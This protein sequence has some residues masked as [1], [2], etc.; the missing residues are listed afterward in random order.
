MSMKLPLVL[1]TATLI[2]GGFA[3]SL[4]DKV[5]LPSLPANVAAAVR[6]EP[7][8]VAQQAVPAD[9][10]ALAQRILTVQ[11]EGQ[12]A[13]DTAV[14]PAAMQ[15]QAQLQPKTRETDQAGDP[16]PPA[17]EP[18]PE[19]DLSALRYFAA[20]GDNARLQAEIA[21]LRALY[22]DWTPPANPLE[23]PM[24]QDERLEEVWR[25]YAEGRYSEVRKAIAERQAMDRTWQPPQDLLERLNLAENRVR[26]INASDLKQYQTVITLAAEAPAL[27]TCS[28]VD[29]LWRLAEAFTRTD[30]ETR[31]VDVY[32][33]VLENCTVEQQRVA[34]VQKAAALLSSSS[35]T[36][37]LA[38]E[39]EKEFEPIRNDLARRLVA[40]ANETPGSD[41]APDYL[42]RLR[43][44]AEAEGKASDALL[45]G[46]YALRHDEARQ[47]EQ[48]FSK[49]GQI[50]KSVSA[51]QGL[52]LSLLKSGQA[53][54]AEDVMYPWRDSSEEASATYLAATA[55]LLAS[56]PS[57]QI[58]TEI[59]QRIAR[60]AL[61]AKYVPTAQQLGW[62]ARA[63]NQPHTAARW[64]ETALQ[65]KA[66]DEP[67]AYGLAITRQQLND[68]AGTEAI[69]AAWAGRSRRIADLGIISA[70][71]PP[72]VA[73]EPVPQSGKGDA[74][75][76]RQ[77]NAAAS[78]V[79]SRQPRPTTSAGRTM[80]DVRSGVENL[81]PQAALQ[82]GWCLMDLNRPL[83]AADAFQAALGS[84]V[85]ATRE[86]AAYGQSLAYLRLGLTDKAA[87]AATKAP[88]SMQRSSELQV[89]IL[90]NRAN[91]AFDAGRYREA[92]IYLDQRALL[93]PETTDLLVLRG[94][95]F[96]NLNRA[97]DAMRIFEAV[98][99]TGNRDA[100]R[101]L[102]D[103]RVA[104]GLETTD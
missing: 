89:A 16:A 50:E 90:A 7:E 80:C 42:E 38:L 36:P 85:Q 64:F 57:P 72:Q 6:S 63:F 55:N 100:A 32:R 19:P 62:Y 14:P 37:L 10:R 46:W 28:D 35:L 49:A 67:S 22:P 74:T 69:R 25:Q 77:T 1:L 95:A 27:R 40:A 96:I 102:R 12:G 20:R 98:A 23:I 82:R 65:W 58:A 66:D 33:Y 51:S 9:P 26:L 11:A 87:V 53:A 17:A 103:A 44:M 99:E 59:L 83:E 54:R 2:G 81:S 8:R 86:D 88:Q 68:R 47:A 13:P 48:W 92:L 93:Q 18:K 94:Y 78:V 52:A 101:G 84:S 43:R 104:L 73:S 60:T 91:L 5:S 41:V 4:R 39:R 31:G 30:R 61:Q 29:V 15:E 70:A 76:S 56:D 79:V 21:R 75:R 3:A 97:G 45:L 24:G 34:T 71:Q